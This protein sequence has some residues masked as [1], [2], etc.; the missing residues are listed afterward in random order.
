MSIRRRIFMAGALATPLAVPLFG[1]AGPHAAAEPTIEIT[2]GWLQVDWTE[3]ALEQLRRFGGEPF[4]VAPA[5]IVGDEANPTLRLPLR[6]VRV[7]PD[8]ADGQGEAEGGFGVRTAEHEVSFQRITRLSGDPRSHAVRTLDGVEHPRSPLSEGRLDEGRV[9]VE[10]GRPGQVAVVRITG[11][12]VRP[13]PEALAVL[14]E[15]LGEPVFAEDTVIAH[16]SARG[17]Y[18]PTR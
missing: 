9:V 13:T 14:T 18:S 10:P 2:N 17:E 12:P 7:T 3:D 11:V 4:A 6:S 5:V 15:V 8:F 1:Q 16:L